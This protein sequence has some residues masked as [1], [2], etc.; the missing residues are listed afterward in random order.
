MS[1]VF[2][3]LF[4]LD[5]LSDCLVV[6]HSLLYYS[7]ELLQSNLLT[8][9]GP[10]MKDVSSD[11]CHQ[12]HVECFLVLSGPAEWFSGGSIFSAVLFHL[13]FPLYWQQSESSVLVCHFLISMSALLHLLTFCFIGST[14][15]N[16]CSKA[17]S[18]LTA[19][20][21]IQE[22]CFV[23][24]VSPISSDILYVPLIFSEGVIHF[25][26][27]CWCPVTFVILFLKK[28]HVIKVPFSSV[29]S[30]YGMMWCG[31]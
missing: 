4:Y 28:Y 29:T 27:G 20:R 19:Y 7:V 22:R 30:F 24:R 9:L 3:F 5:L 15:K 14:D 10:S 12:Y 23:R 31:S 25:S 26:C 11:G 6:Q 8:T 13:A 18:C 1:T 16:C 21:T 2:H 17:I